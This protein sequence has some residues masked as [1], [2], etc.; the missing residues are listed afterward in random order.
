[1]KTEKKKK[2]KAIHFKGILDLDPTK[3]S[4]IHDPRPFSTKIASGSATLNNEN[5]KYERV[6]K[7]TL[8]NIFVF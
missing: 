2:S 1:M 8:E 7:D 3:G 5:S 6:E 4:I